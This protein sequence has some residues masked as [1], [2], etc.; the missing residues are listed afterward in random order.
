MQITLIYLIYIESLM[1]SKAKTLS[2]A[3]DNF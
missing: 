3:F 2:L 1:Y